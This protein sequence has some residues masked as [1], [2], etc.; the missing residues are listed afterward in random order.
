MKLILLVCP[1]C[2]QPLHPDKEDVVI[3]CPNCHTPVAIAVNGPQKMTVH[4]AVPG[5]K[6]ASGKR[7]FPFWVF[8]GRAHILKRETQGGSRS[9]RKDSEKLWGASRRLYVPAWEIDLHNAQ[10]IGSQLIQ[11]QPEV[12]FVNSPEDAQ[13]ISATVTP[14]DARK[15]LEFVVL[16][17]EARRRD[18]LKDLEFNLEINDPELWGMPEGTF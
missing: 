15:L 5:K 7:W 3:A 9:G 18:W 12:Q 14:T 8:E 4:Y 2:G 11:K 16:A 10:E 1:N 6:S 17:I 13:L